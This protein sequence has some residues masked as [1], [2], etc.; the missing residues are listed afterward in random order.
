MDESAAGEV[1]ISN[2]PQF[3]FRGDDVV[4]VSDRS[5]RMRT[6]AEER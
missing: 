6:P 4:E 2:Q 5:N 1:L 3:N